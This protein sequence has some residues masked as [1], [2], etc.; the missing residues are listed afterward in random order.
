MSRNRRQIVVS[1]HALLRFIERAG[2]LDVNA[3][4]T[5]LAMSLERAA[6]LAD[7]AGQRR[8]RVAAD[9]LTYVVV[10][11]GPT[12]TIVTIVGGPAYFPPRAAKAPAQEA[13]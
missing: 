2:G 8:Y 4:R 11:D 7:A 3:I 10:A 13:D 9:G 6:A 1:D 5:A 12:T